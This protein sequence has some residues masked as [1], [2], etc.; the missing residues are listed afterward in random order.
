MESRSRARAE[1]LERVAPPLFVFLWSTGFIGAKYIHPYAEPFTF[2][3]IRYALAAT[4]LFI[5][6]IATGAPRTLTRSQL[7]RSVLVALFLHVTYIGAVFYAVSLGVPAG[8]TAIIVGLQPVVVAV[9]AIPLLGERMHWQQ[10]AGLT[11]GVVGIALL[12]L[13]KVFEGDY[14][15]VYSGVGILACFIA[16]SATSMGYLL[17]KKLGGGIPFLAGTGAQYVA[18]ALIF[19]L[20]AL[21][22]EDRTVQWT[23]EFVF[24]LGWLTVMLSIASIL[25]LYGM[26]ARGTAGNVASLMYLVPPTAAVIAY[27][28]FGEVISLVGVIGIAIAGVGVLLVRAHR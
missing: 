19:A 25:L 18:S 3:T 28:V 24:G 9:L 4:L 20:L 21:T 23:A 15:T 27:L 6:A 11:L 14:S 22:T 7:M 1:L 13:P 5:V 16:L 10:A 12:L 8:I 17:Q 2:L 26:L